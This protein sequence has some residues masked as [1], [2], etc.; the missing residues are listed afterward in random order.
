MSEITDFYLSWQGSS[1]FGSSGIRVRDQEPVVF[2]PTDISGC[3]MWLDANDNDTVNYNDLLQVTSWE[4]KGTLGGQFDLSGGIIG[5]GQAT[6]NGLNTVSFNS[7]AFMSGQF[8][9]DFQN[10]SLFIVT[11]ETGVPSGIPSPWITCDTNGGMES[12]SQHDGTTVYYIGK[13]NVVFPELAAE[14]ATDY[15]DYAA[16]FSFVNASDLSD[17]YVG[18]NRT[19]ITITYNNIASGYN[20]NLITY[21]LGDFVNGTSVG[22]SQDMCEVILYNTA[23]SA[24]ERENVEVYLM[25]KWAIVEPPAPPPPPFVPTDIS[26]LQLWLDANNM[27]TLTLSGTDVLSWSNL[28]S[29]G[30]TYD[31]Q[32]NVASIVAGP[33]STKMIEF[34]GTATLSNYS[35]V[36]YYSRTAFCAFQTIS[37]LTKL[38][39]P[40]VNLMNTDATGGR[41]FALAYDSNTSTYY[42]ELCQQGYNCPAGGAIPAVDTKMALGIWA[43]DSNTVASNTAYWNGGS[44]INTNTDLGNLFNTFPIPY[45]IGSPNF[46]SPDFRVGEI[47]EYD[48]VLT[49]AQISTVADYLV[50]KW[51]ISSFTSIS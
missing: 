2:K 3:V 6:Q 12:F 16:L 15:T 51:A 20:T 41:Q 38:S 19:P 11:R 36:P 10:R 29:I 23:L 18:V 50:N 40:Y 35:V 47:L 48:S 8:Q 31:A 17:N 37:D 49:T 39:Y 46:G 1:G 34:P 9:F 45:Y 43:C 24:P 7:N 13:H 4:N 26:G 22:N 14:S 5:Y 44:N 21:F 25:T 32:C 42:M 28:G 27:S 30:T 33:G